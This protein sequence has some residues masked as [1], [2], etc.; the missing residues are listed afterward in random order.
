MIRAKLGPRL[1]MR[2][3]PELEFAYDAGR[4]EVA[5]LDAVLYEVEREL[6]ESE[7]KKP[8]EGEGSPGAG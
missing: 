6:K 3:T 7:A 4:E 2:R 1:G 8:P 5:R